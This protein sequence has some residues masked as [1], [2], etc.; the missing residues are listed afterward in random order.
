VSD[1]VYALINR[2]LSHMTGRVDR[3][4]MR[5]ALSAQK[6]RGADAS[7]VNHY[8]FGAQ[9]REKTRRAFFTSLAPL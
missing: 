1:S 5:L 9:K 2:R 7:S 8:T 4:R 3:E 6:L